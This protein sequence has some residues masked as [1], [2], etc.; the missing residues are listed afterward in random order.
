MKKSKKKKKKRK[1]REKKEKKKKPNPNKNP[2]HQT[3]DTRRNQ[4]E[5]KKNSVPRS[6]R[7]GFALGR[8]VLLLFPL[9]NVVRALI[10]GPGN[11]ALLSPTSI[12]QGC[13]Q[14]LSCSGHQHGGR[15]QGFLEG[16]QLPLCLLV[17]EMG[18]LF[19]ALAALQCA[20]QPLAPVFLA[21]ALGFRGVYFRAVVAR[22]A[23]IR[24]F[25]IAFLVIICPIDNGPLWGGDRGILCWA[26]LGWGGRCRLVWAGLWSFGPE[27]RGSGAHSS[28]RPRNGDGLPRHWWTKVCKLST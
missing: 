23:G 18:G 21:P 20:R 9:L 14:L 17:G 4:R 22:C 19:G 15:S 3:E 13:L 5:R 1:K 7:S 28:A 25:F 27:H 10:P 16:T 12:L 26:I 6:F 24:N 2:H 8:I 11:Y